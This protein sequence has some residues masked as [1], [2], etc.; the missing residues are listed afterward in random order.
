[1][2][3]DPIITVNVTLTTPE[4][5]TAF[6]HALN[7]SPQAAL[8]AVL[9]SIGVTP[10]PAISEPAPAAPVY[11]PTA[12][13]PVTPTVTPVNAPAPV[14]VPTSAPEYTFDVLARAAAPLMDAGK[15]PDLQALL[16]SFNIQALTQ[17][18]KEQYGAFATGLRGLGARI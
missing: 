6:F 8:P 17:L 14:P 12:A 11:T 1:M 15:T 10:A 16:R 18:P 13:V 9:S 7:G 5:V 2:L 3:T 4:A